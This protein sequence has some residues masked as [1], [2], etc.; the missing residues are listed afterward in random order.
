MT[1]FLSEKTKYTT[2]KAIAMLAILLV[3]S[4]IYT[5]NQLKTL[6]SY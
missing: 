1:N 2:N 6:M 5:Y 4:L 3:F